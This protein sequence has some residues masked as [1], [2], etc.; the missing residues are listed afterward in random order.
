MSELQAYHEV[1]V[2]SERGF[3]L[4]F[5]AVF[6]VLGLYPLLNDGKVF[7]WALGV[8]VIFLLL[9]LLVPT[10][11]AIPNRLWFRFGMLLSKIVNPLIMGIIFFIVLTPFGLLKRV[12]CRD[13][14][15]R[16]LQPGAESYWQPRDE[17]NNP[18]GSMKNQ[19]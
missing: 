15:T 13:P 3:G 16:K 9:A 12:F 4:V 11:L 1:T 7:H 19:F 6:F 2:G 10:S 5:S 8:S 17:K 14:G 18:M